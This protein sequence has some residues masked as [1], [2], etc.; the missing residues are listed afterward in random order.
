M[1]RPER[2]DAD[3]FPFFVKDGKTLYILETRYGLEGIGFF[4]NL[5]RFLTS[6]YDHHICVADEADRLYFFSQIHCPDE[7]KGMDMLNL[8]A[9]TGKIERELWTKKRVIVSPD[10]LNSLNGAY[11]NRKNKIIT[12]EEIGVSYTNNP[13]TSGFTQLNPEK[14]GHNPQKKKEEKKLK[15]STSGVSYVGNGDGENQPPLPDTDEPIGEP[16]ATDRKEALVEEPEEPK[17]PSRNTHGERWTPEQLSDLETE[18]KDIL[19]R[20][21]SRFHQQCYL[22]T[23]ENYNRGNP[24][25]VI[26]C[27][28]SLIKQKMGGINITWPKAWLDKAFEDQNGKFEAAESER[29]SQQ[30]KEDIFNGRGKEV[31]GGRGNRLQPDGGVSE[32]ESKRNIERLHGLVQGI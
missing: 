24:E 8:M 7:E 19:S 16:P 25:A 31:N 11:L 5:M 13:I 32:K 6:Q 21:G 28:R 3:Y 9:K 4:T 12:I 26:F 22:F 18:M 30:Y 15:E 20:Y 1:A 2:H 10:L 17:T 29:E 14:E 27:L 23:Q